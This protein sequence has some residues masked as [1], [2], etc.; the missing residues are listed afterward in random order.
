MRSLAS[1]QLI[2]DRLCKLGPRIEP[3]LTDINLRSA[4]FLIPASILCA[5][6]DETEVTQ[7]V[8]VRLE[9]KLLT[10]ETDHVPTKIVQDFRS[11]VLMHCL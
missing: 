6:K 11:Q 4:V 5:S 2:L 10:I 7:I 8:I 3:N 9:V 1:L